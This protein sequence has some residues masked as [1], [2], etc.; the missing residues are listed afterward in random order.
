MEFFKWSTAWTIHLV[1]LAAGILIGYCFF[2]LPDWACGLLRDDLAPLWAAAV[3]GLLAAI[4][5]FAA[6]I[7]AL[8]TG[9]DAINAERDLRRQEVSAA[10][11][12]RM[13]THKAIAALYAPALYN[14]SFSAARWMYMCDDKRLSFVEVIN[15]IRSN[16]MEHLGAA[17]PAIEKLPPKYSL[18]FGEA[19]V[20]I[21]TLI[22]QAG[23]FEPQ[24][25][26]WDDAMIDQQ[27]KNVRG[28][29]TGIK[30]DAYE[31]WKLYEELAAISDG[32][33]EDPLTAAE[34]LYKD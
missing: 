23:H 27:R 21:S 18:A 5:T 29:V 13:Q 2:Y 30:E 17:V 15:Q 16:R 22:N 20:K 12:E 10:A 3:A 8:R 34:R 14:L 26:H 9:R 28:L 31:A 25:R 32:V 11:E 24:M 7:A 19:L 6:V 1:C 33:E 4:A